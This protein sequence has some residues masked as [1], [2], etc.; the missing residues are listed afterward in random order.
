MGQGLGVI[1][2]ELSSA[3]Q[4]H[5]ERLERP[6][7]YKRLQ[8]PFEVRSFHHRINRSKRREQSG[9]PLTGLSPRPNAGKAMVAGP[10]P[11]DLPRK[12]ELQLRDLLFPPISRGQSPTSQG[13][14]ADGV[15]GCQ[16]RSFA[17]LVSRIRK[18]YVVKTCP[19]PVISV[20]LK[21]DTG[22]RGHDSVSA[23]RHAPRRSA[24]FL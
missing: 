20:A 3:C 18:S 21:S 12:P 4:L 15:P 5:S 11:N 6:A 22:A 7:L 9:P 19:P 2:G 13:L 1:N 16:A 24:R 8:D 17:N 23:I 10:T 14:S